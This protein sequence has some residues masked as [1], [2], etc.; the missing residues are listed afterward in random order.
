[1]LLSEFIHAYLQLY[2]KNI[3][4]N[5]VNVK[6]RLLY[7]LFYALQNMAYDKKYDNYDHL[8]T[9]GVNSAFV[10]QLKNLK[11]I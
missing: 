2:I 3:I 7:L 1:M 4:I 6:C 10:K 8:M 5:I 9:A 11:I